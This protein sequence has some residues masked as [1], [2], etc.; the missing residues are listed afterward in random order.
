MTR[1]PRATHVTDDGNEALRAQGASCANCSS[2][3][4]TGPYGPHCKVDRY[5]LGYAVADP[6][7]LCSRWSAR[8]A[9]PAR[10]EEG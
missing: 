2:F 8:E 6:D 7:N 5:F 9:T 3:R 10:G 1:W 4:R